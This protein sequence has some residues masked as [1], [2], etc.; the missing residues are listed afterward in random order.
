MRDCSGLTCV[1]VTPPPGFHLDTSCYPLLLAPA[2]LNL[3]LHITA[4]R[5]DGYHNLQTLF[6]LLDY[7]DLLQLVPRADQRC[8]IHD[9]K[10]RIELSQNLIYK[11]WRLLSQYALEKQWISKGF[12]YGVDI[13]LDKKIPV[14]GG[15]GGGSSNAA[16]TLLQL[17]HLWHL[18]LEQ[19]Q[20]AHLG[21]K[22]GADVPVFVH[23]KNCWAEGVG[24]KI[25]PVDLPSYYFLVVR[26][27]IA[28]RTAELF[29]HKALKRNC[30]PLAWHNWSFQHSGNVFE[31]LVQQL[32]P[33]MKAVFT[34]LSQLSKHL[35]SYYPPR[36][37]GTGSCVFLTFTDKP[38][39]EAARQRV[40]KYYECFCAQGHQEVR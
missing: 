29:Q 4:R 36:L 20:L 35:Q 34:D 9:P 10:S 39:C 37:S 13:Y 16:I 33:Q 6:Q 38:N 30:P 32:Y 19:A 15:L 2:K 5:N 17:S 14:G 24:E 1:N 25:T 23:H 26:P 11:A 21:L 7:G 18:P 31:P 12:S 40:Q 28:I 3:F 22:L 27:D 8:L